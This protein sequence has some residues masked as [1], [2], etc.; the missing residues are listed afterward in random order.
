MSLPPMAWALGLFLTVIV[1]QRMVELSISAR[2]SRRLK[3]RGAREHGRWHFPLLVVVHVLYPLLLAAEVGGWGTEPGPWWPL[4]LGLWLAAQALRFSAI[5]ELGEHWNVRILVVPGAPLVRTGPYRWLRHPN[6]V[7][8]V[9]ELMAGPMLFGAWR[10]A[11]LISALNAIALTIRIRA[12]ERALGPEP[13][14]V[15]RVPVTTATR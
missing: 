8:V 13:L 10:T 12:E 1:F 5:R 15:H 7:A 3:R 6:Y 9:I 2:N 4:W 11:L 14:D